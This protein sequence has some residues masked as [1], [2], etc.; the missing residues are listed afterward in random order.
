VGLFNPSVEAQ[1]H[2]NGPK[3]SCEIN[4]V[5]AL[6]AATRN[7]LKAMWRARAATLRNF[8]DFWAGGGEKSLHSELQDGLW[9]RGAGTT[10]EDALSS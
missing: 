9:S 6:R 4:H 5:L 2:L 3:S 7:L 1:G 10:H 8:P